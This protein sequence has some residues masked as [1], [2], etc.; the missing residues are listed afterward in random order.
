MIMIVI[1]KN[2]DNDENHKNIMTIS[3]TI[4]SD[5]ID[6]DILMIMKIETLIMAQ[7]ANDEITMIKKIIITT[8]SRDHK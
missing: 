7:I 2:N 3:A 4:D 6:S 8:T 5:S 1:Q